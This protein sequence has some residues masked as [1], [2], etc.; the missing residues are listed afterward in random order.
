MKKGGA[1][2]ASLFFTKK[3]RKGL[4]L[5]GSFGADEG[6]RTPTPLVLV[7]KTY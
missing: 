6:T 1:G 5:Y 3:N 4:K 2:L 7:P